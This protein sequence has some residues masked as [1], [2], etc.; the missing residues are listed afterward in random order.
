MSL[1]DWQD[2]LDN[3]QFFLFIDLIKIGIPSGNVQP[4]DDH[5]AF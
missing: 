2:L 1:F 4:V 5:P 3:H